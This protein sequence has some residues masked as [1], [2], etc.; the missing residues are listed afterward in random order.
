MVL[1]YACVCVFGDVVQLGEH[2]TST[3]LT[4]VQFPGA[5][6]EFAPRVNFQCRLPYSVCIPLCAIACINIC[7][8]I[9]DPGVHIRAQWIM[10]TLKHPACTIGCI[11]QLCHNW[12]FLG[13]ATQISHGRNP[14]G[15]HSCKKFLI[16]DKK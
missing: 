4:H 15:K 14:L 1:V 11:A 5:A 12:L 8:H 2:Q 16:E 10:E 3:P 13:R 9:K 6:R 7:A